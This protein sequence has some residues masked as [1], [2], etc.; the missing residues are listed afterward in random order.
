MFDRLT[1]WGSFSY[2]CVAHVGFIHFSLLILPAE[3]V[4]KGDG[5]HWPMADP[6]PWCSSIARRLEAVVGGTANLADVILAAGDAAIATA[7]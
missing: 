4:K 5:E 2:L 6:G 3:N 1:A 7:F